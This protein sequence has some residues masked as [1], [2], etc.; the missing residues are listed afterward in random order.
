MQPLDNCR[1][2][3]MTVKSS[4]SSLN[5]HHFFV[6]SGSQPTTA[7][8]DRTLAINSGRFNSSSGF[9]TTSSPI[10]ITPLHSGSLTWMRIGVLTLAAHHHLMASGV[11]VHTIK[12]LKSELMA[13]LN[14]TV[15]QLG[16][17]TIEFV[18][19]AISQWQPKPGAQP[20]LV[21]A[22]HACD[23]A[24]DDAIAKQLHGRAH[25]CSSLHV[26]NMIF[27]AKSIDRTFLLGSS[28]SFATASFANVSVTS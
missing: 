19:E 15:E 26:V 14:S 28:H 18:T 1:P 5:R 21:I 3:S 20:D 23:T 7:R 13:Q 10:T 16:W 8:Y 11:N 6:T 27:S 12:G 9:S 2:P 22:L 25:I 24:T 4:I 17:S